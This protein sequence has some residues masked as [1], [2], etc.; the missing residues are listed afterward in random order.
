MIAVCYPELQRHMV[1]VLAVSVDSVNDHKVWD[2]TELSKMVVGG[3]P[4]PMLE[5][6]GGRIARLYDIWDGSN[7][8]V[9]RACILIDPQ[10]VVQSFQLLN[11]HIGPSIPE[12]VREI[13]ALQYHRATGDAVPANWRPGRPTIKPSIQLAGHVWQI[14]RPVKEC[15]PR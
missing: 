1:E 13:E 4:F 3:V 7:G 5:D 8:I 6:R 15:N 14:W 2:E 10:G 9:A 12:W 11:Q